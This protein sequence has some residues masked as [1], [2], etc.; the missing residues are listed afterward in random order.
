MAVD[1][2]RLPD[3]GPTPSFRFPSIVRHT[4]ASGLDLR[5]IEHASIPVVSLVLV[6]RGGLGAD[7]PT[8][9]GL[10]ALTADLADEGTP[11]LSAIEVSDALAR[12]GGDFDVEVGADAVAFSLVTLTKFADRGAG[13]FADIAT[14]PALREEDFS[15]V[16]QQ[17]LDRLTQLRVVPQALA[18]CAF[19]RLLY[20]GHPYG[21][22]AIGSTATL[23]SIALD[24]VRRFHRAAF[25]P[26][27]AVLVVA[28]ALSH[29]QLREVGARAFS[30]WTD[31]TSV[32][33]VQVAADIEPPLASLVRRA[34][35]PRT[36]AA[37]SELRI[38]HL[39]ARRNTPD[40]SALLVMNAVLGGQFTSRVN[41]KL[42]EEKGF[43]YG[44]HTGFDWRHG[45]GP[46]SLEASVHT[47][48][49]AEA[50]S[51]S[52]RELEDIRGARP[53]TP[54]EMALAKASLTRGYPRGFETAEQVARST[55]SHALHGLPDTYFDE[56]VPRIE[57][58]TIEDVVRV[59]GQYIDPA[60]LIT[61]VV[62][63]Y[64][65]IGASLDQLGLGDW[66]VLPAEL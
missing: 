31:T 18:E 7:P 36:G 57:A 12:I 64:A 52:L 14:R 50:I 42:R 24:E 40:Y 20:G 9:E 61:L 66:T 26:S 19:H 59:A 21:H 37:Q 28:G 3:L 46:F 47:A 11:D 39:S 65:Q 33:A 16:R 32:D 15:R 38:G 45:L 49:T 58:V 17:R 56:F 62:G 29:E 23:G 41:L 1:R 2:T 22:L 55:A 13:L 10:A 44:A 35:V 27:R 63:D 4:L 60:R 6:V 48:S 43:T 53:P 8:R 25:Q 30:D 5:T 51:D 34:V 54:E